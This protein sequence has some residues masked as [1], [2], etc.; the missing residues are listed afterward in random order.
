MILIGTLTSHMNINFQRKVD[1][2]IGTFICRIFSLFY[3]KSK[4]EDDGVQAKKFLVILLS[5]RGNLVLAYPMF[6]QIK[7]RY[8]KAELYGLLF[9]KNREILTL[10]DVTAPENILT[11]RDTSFGVFTFDCLR[12]LNRIRKLKVDVV[13]DCELFSRVSSISVRIS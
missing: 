4:D 2:Y 5:E 9:E 6:Q 3:R 10:L 12:V 8:P 7:K 13:I 11:I 1:R